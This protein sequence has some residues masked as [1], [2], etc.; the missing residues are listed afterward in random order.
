MMVFRKTLFEQSKSIN[1][2]EKR[3]F[4]PYLDALEGREAI[5]EPGDKHYT[6]DLSEAECIYPI[7][8]D[9]LSDDLSIFS[10]LKG[11]NYGA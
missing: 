1:E 9:W 3:K 7:Y 2:S 10:M 11:V 6:I 5:K 4:R 8:A